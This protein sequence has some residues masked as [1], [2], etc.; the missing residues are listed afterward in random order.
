MRLRFVDE[1]LVIENV[2]RSSHQ[3]EAHSCIALVAGWE[4]ILAMHDYLM[5][6]AMLAVVDYFVNP[7]F[8]YR[9]ARKKQ[10]GMFPAIAH[11]TWTAPAKP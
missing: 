9:L 2:R 1:I 7:G 3:L 11:A 6:G 8:R 10:A 4:G 5:A